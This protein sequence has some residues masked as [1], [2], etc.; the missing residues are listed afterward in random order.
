[1]FKKALCIKYRQK[2]KYYLKETVIT[3]V[4]LNSWKLKRKNTEGG[5]YTQDH[6][7]FSIKD[8]SKEM[9]LHLTPT[10]VVYYLICIQN[11]PTHQ[12]TIILLL[13]LATPCRSVMKVVQSLQYLSSETPCKT[14]KTLS[15]AFCYY[16]I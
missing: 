14:S 3:L 11:R 6:A 13:F 9:P 16:D 4:T 5:I 15:L 10:S 7:L 2:T 1:M 12:L 8:T